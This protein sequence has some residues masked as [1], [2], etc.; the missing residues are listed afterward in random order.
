MRLILIVL[1]ASLGSA[2]IATAQS[3]VKTADYS[4]DYK[5]PPAAA[6]I[7]PLRQWLDADRARQRGSI[8]SDAASGRAESRDG[9]IAFHK[10]EASTTWEVVTETP[11]FLSLSGESWSYTGGAHGNGNARALLWDKTAHRRLES[12]AVFVSPAA[13]QDVLGPAWCRW[14][15]AERMRKMGVPAQAD[16]PFAKCPLV[17][18]LTLLLGSSTRRKIDRIGLIA[19]PYV[20]GSY[21]EG[22]YEMSLPVTAALLRAVKPAYRDAFAVP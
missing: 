15:K 18:E 8:A 1:L 2:T 22:S 3:S 7:A 19:D 21:A 6:R 11:R 13:L 17:S 12:K 4:F 10:Y 14:I 16:D 20:A 9:A 5:Y